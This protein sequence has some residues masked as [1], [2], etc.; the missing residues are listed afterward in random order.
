MVVGQ[1]A[2]RCGVARTQTNDW[3]QI[4][5]SRKRSTDAN[6][7]AEQRLSARLIPSPLL[8]S[9]SVGRARF[10]SYACQIGHDNLLVVPGRHVESR[11]SVVVDVSQAC[12]VIDE[13]FHDFERGVSRRPCAMGC[14]FH[15]PLRRSGLHDPPTTLC[16]RCRPGVRRRAIT[17]RLPSFSLISTP[18]SRQ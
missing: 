8:F 18:D 13:Q 16:R 15:H 4:V 11:F 7:W 5:F 12:A 10:R 2:T 3:R 1:Q 14:C 9:P 17:L 6:T